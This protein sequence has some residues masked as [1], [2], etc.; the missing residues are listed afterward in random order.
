MC[1]PTNEIGIKTAYYI[2]VTVIVDPLHLKQTG[3]EQIM[4]SMF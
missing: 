2:D 1:L 3:F 4:V